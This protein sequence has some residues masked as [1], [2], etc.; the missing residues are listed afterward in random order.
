MPL[1]TIRLHEAAREISRIVQGFGSIIHE[2]RMSER[3]LAAYLDACVDEG[4]NT[5]DLAAV[6]SGGAAESVFG[7]ALTL[8]PGLRERLTVITKY[9]IEG[10][11]AGYHCYDTSREAIVRSAE[12]SLRR[13]GTD[14]IDVLLMHRPDMLMDADEVAEALLSLRKAGKALCFGVSNFLPHQV[15]LLASRLPFPLAVNEVPYNLFD[16]DMQENGTLDLC[17]RLRIAPLFYSPL[18]GGRLFAPANA[19]DRH[20]LETL[21]EVARQHGDAP[22]EQIAIA[23]VLRHPAR[24]AA[25]LGGGRAEWM[26]RAA[27]G[28]R[29]A[30]TRDQWFRLWTASKGYEIP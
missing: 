6:Y 4:I 20:L 7:G 30:L 27:A 15:E 25:I 10:E 29:I 23:W 11:G 14:H 1:P 16:M 2:E 12:R 26:R 24:G 19:R 18:G 5:C 13:M 21:R 3:E 9:G 8:R 28:A 17:Q 22:V